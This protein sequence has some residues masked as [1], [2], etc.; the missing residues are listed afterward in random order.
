CSTACARGGGRSGA[1]LRWRRVQVRTS[2]PA[3]FCDVLKRALSRSPSAMLA[4]QGVARGD[5]YNFFCQAEDGI[6][7]WSV[8]GVQTCALPICSVRLC[9]PGA[10]GSPLN[11]DWAA[12]RTLL[13]R[14]VEPNA[15]IAG[16]SRAWRLHG[17]IS[18]ISAIEDP[19][20]GG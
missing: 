10:F 1:C 11:P 13:A 4:C 8:T 12:I 16:R 2:L 7:D 20:S 3:W 15:L 18:S 14:K 5:A 9:A 17:P 6:R 19:K